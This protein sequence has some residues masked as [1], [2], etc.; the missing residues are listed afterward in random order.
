MCNGRYSN[1]A[2][3]RSLLEQV[4][5][6]ALNASEAVQFDRQTDDDDA[7]IVRHQHLK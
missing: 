1:L 5:V 4:L 2:T 3:I 7:K 6:F